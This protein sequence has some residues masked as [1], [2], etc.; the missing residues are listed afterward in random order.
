MECRHLR[1]TIG[2]ATASSRTKPITATQ[3]TVLS[4]N[5]PLGI[6]Y[7]VLWIFSVPILTPLRKI[8]VHVVQTP[9]VAWET[10]H[11]GG[12]VPQLS[13]FL[14]SVGDRAIEIRMIERAVE[15]RLIAGNSVAEGKRRCCSSTTSKLPFCFRGQAVRVLVTFLQ[16]PD[17]LLTILPG[18]RI[19]REF[20]FVAYETAWIVAHDRLPLVLSHKMYSHVK[21]LGQRDRMLSF[22]GSFVDR[23]AFFSR[24]TPHHERT[25]RNPGKPYTQAVRPR[26]A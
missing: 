19:D 4:H 25:G 23:P 15:V 26:R 8:A 21:P 18:N 12:L 9:S 13:A 20:P 5:R 1:V 24:R 11:G 6:K 3:H 14:S 10:A 17:E 7:V 2:R 16:Y 22:T